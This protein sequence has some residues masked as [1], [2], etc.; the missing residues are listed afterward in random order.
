MM[1]IPDQ[2]RNACHAVRRKDYPLAN[3][4]PTMQMA[5]D[6]I[7]TLRTQLREQGQTLDRYRAEVGA[8]HAHVATSGYVRVIDGKRVPIPRYIGPEDAE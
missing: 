1:D 8:L 5:A 3:L 4:I 6:V 2:L 7:D